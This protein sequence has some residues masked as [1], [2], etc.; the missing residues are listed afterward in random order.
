MSL[1][2]TASRGVA[3]RLADD[4]DRLVHMRFFDVQRRQ[5]PQDVVVR[6]YGD[7]P[8]LNALRGDRIAVDF[9][10]D[11][12]PMG[13]MLKA[14]GARRIQVAVTGC[15][16]LDRIEILRKKLVQM[17]QDLYSGPDT[18]GNAWKR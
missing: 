8:V 11:D 5:E 17:P 1:P 10:L 14:S 7:K 2:A 6:A 4:L 18:C 9:Q 16:A 12:Q 15:D 3:K 13:S